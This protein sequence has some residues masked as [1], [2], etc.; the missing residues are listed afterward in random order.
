MNLF[1]ATMSFK[2]KRSSSGF[3]NLENTVY[4]STHA[5]LK[6]DFPKMD[7]LEFQNLSFPTFFEIVPWTEP[8]SVVEGS[9]YFKKFI[10][11]RVFNKH[12]FISTEYY[13]RVVNNFPASHVIK[14]SK[15]L[16]PW[17]IIVGILKNSVY[18]I[19]CSH[20]LKLH[21]PKVSTLYLFQFCTRLFCISD[22][23]ICPASYYN[24]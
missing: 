5:N 19:V 14:N 2:P 20:E 7:I 18:V 17:F 11:T 8:M 3:W 16:S 4:Y 23:V 6:R 12:K 13:R 15:Y 10:F 22:H 24:I 21:L 1:K 9:R